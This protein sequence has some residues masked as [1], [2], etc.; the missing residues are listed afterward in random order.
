MAKLILENL[1]DELF[2]EIEKLAQQKNNSVNEQTINLLKIALEKTETPL[3]IM[4]S[5]DNDPTWEE[6]VKNTPQV[7]QDIRNAPRVNPANYGLLDST[8]LIREDRDR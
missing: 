8:E 7:L 4:V 3:K 5:P 2:Q 6:R 1:P